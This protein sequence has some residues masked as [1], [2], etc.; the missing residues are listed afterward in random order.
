MPC[1]S[2]FTYYTSIEGLNEVQHAKITQPA[3]EGEWKLSWNWKVSSIF[4]TIRSGL[5]VAAH[6]LSRIRSPA[7]GCNDRCPPRTSRPRRGLHLSGPVR[8]ITIGAKQQWNH[9][10]SRFF[11]ISNLLQPFRPL[12]N[13]LLKWCLGSLDLGLPLLFFPM[14]IPFFHDFLQL[15]LCIEDINAPE[16]KKPFYFWFHKQDLFKYLTFRLKRWNFPSFNTSKII[17]YLTWW[18]CNGE[19]IKNCRLDL[20]K[21]TMECWNVENNIINGFGLGTKSSKNLIIILK[22]LP[23]HPS[24]KCALCATLKHISVKWNKN[25]F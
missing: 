23:V 19:P 3:G 15:T 17:M 7:P 21:D 6:G 10:A 12:L 22:L 11:C 18:W 1:F 9:M 8:S 4:M 13:H 16:K 25:S 20:K 14:A 2:S 5:F 24:L